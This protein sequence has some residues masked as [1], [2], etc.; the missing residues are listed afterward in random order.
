MK[1]VK[2]KDTSFWILTDNDLNIKLSIFYNYYLHN[3]YNTL[4]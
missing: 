1:N 4:H 2:I 3:P